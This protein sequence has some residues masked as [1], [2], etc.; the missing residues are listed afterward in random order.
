MN[1]AHRPRKRGTATFYTVAEA[2]FFAG[3]TALLNSLRLTGNDGELVVLDCGLLPEQRARLEPHVTLVDAPEAVTRNPYLIKPFPSQ[4][5]PRGVVVIIDS[6][7]IVTRSLQEV[8]E[9][10]RS[11][12]ICVFP[13]HAGTITRWVPE[14]EDVFELRRPLRREHYRNAGFVAL[15]L[16][17]WPDFLE[18]WW[19][20][21]QHIP[22]DRTMHVGTSFSDP[23]WGADQDAL[24]ALLMSE[25]EVDAVHELPFL[26]A[27]RE[28]WL[29]QVKVVDART[30]ECRMDGVTPV[31]LHYTGKPKPWQP[32]AW[33]RVRARA[34]ERLLKRLFFE[35]DVLVPLEPKELPA[36]LRP[37]VGSL[38][39]LNM[40][41]VMN[42]T[43]RFFVHLASGGFRDR[44]TKLRDR[45]GG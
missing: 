44:L 11:G 30:L 10:A 13:E 34:F 31:L 41:S 17:H 18:R 32:Q 27:P 22:A 40:L 19:E 37:G 38:V 15:S 7:M 29:R 21:A 25:L 2:R 9:L 28:W 39:L 16:D 1:G 24:N 26:E 36:W 33:M 20:L 5:Q 8:V 6:D 4:L 43:V 35:S 14:W 23:F 45:L 42:S 12:K 3:V